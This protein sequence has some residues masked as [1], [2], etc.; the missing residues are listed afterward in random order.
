M[1]TAAGKIPDSWKL[2]YLLAGHTNQELHAAQIDRND[3]GYLIKFILSEAVAEGPDTGLKLPST[4][5]CSQ[6]AWELA[7]TCSYE[8][9]SAKSMQPYD[10]HPWMINRTYASGPLGSAAPTPLAASIGRPDLRCLAALSTII[11]DH[12][13]WTHPQ[14]I[15][16][17]VASHFTACI[18]LMGQ[19]E[20]LLLITTWISLAVFAVALQ[21]THSSTHAHMRVHEHHGLHK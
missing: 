17:G 20:M 15:S 21:T 4:E 2:S 11:M 16:E 3:T 18:P 13:D 5:K 8:A 1:V 19:I 10:Q 12:L 9:H 6:L 7:C 14:T